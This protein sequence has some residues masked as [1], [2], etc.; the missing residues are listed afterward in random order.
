MNEKLIWMLAVILTLCDFASCRKSG[1]LSSSSKY[2]RRAW[3]ILSVKTPSSYFR[4][5]T[6]ISFSNS[7][8]ACPTASIL[9]VGSKR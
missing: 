1:S 4:N 6:T 8:I 3:E 9:S 2:R 5:S 7:L